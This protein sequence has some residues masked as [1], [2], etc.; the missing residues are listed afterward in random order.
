MQTERHDP[1]RILDIPLAMLLST[2]CIIGRESVTGTASGSASASGTGT[3]T[4]HGRATDDLPGET[5]VVTTAADSTSMGTMNS[6]ESTAD[7]PLADP[8]L[9]F[10]AELCPPECAVIGAHTQAISGCWGGYQDTVDLCITPGEPTA[11][12]TSFFIEL[13]GE[14]FYALRGHPCVNNVT[15]VPTL[16][17][18]CSASDGE[19]DGCQC[20]CGSAGCPHEFELMM[21]NQC[22]LPSPCGPSVLHKWFED[23]TDYDLCVLQGLRD[24]VP[25]AYDMVYLNG[26]VFEHSRVYVGDGPDVRLLH[27]IQGDIPC[28]NAPMFDAWDP[29]RTGTLRPRAWFEDCLQATDPD[30]QYT[31]LYGPQWLE[32]AETL[33]AVCP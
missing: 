12:R 7:P 5:A 6:S 24:R 8:C 29:A 13:E 20:L 14:T 30:S 31:C 21:L 33:P 2:G 10:P 19:P 4:G 18:E 1:L 32:N 9:E 15:A 22:G 3:T 23:Y 26:L 17:S 16:W 11:G 27:R 25:G 28:P